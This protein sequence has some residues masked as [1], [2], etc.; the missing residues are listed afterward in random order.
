LTES[1]TIVTSDKNSETAIEKQPVSDSTTR[2]ASRPM[3]QYVIC[4][5]NQNS[6]R[7]KTDETA[8]IL[9]RGDFKCLDQLSRF[10]QYF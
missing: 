4:I 3:H 8:T 9:L 5:Q 10:V 6:F 7:I 2:F 1:N